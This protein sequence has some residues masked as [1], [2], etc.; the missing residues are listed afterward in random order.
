MVVPSFDLT[1]PSDDRG[2]FQ[3]L[4]SGRRVTGHVAG[5]FIDVWSRFVIQVP[6]V[7]T[8]SIHEKAATAAGNPLVVMAR[9]ATCRTSSGEAPAARARRVFERTAPS[10]DA[11]M[12]MPSSGAARC[13]PLR[14]ARRRS[15]WLHRGCRGPQRRSGSAIAGEDRHQANTPRSRL[16]LSV[17]LDIAPSYGIARAASWQRLPSF[18]A[19]A[20]CDILHSSHSRNCSRCS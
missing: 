2:G 9:T 17:S 18:R 1:A 10:A 12:A 13:A 11:P 6:A 15:Q 7:S 3:F 16:F 20:R 19:A 8:S 14:R 5:G 4:K